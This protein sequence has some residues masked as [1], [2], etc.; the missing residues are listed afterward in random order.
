ME[1][2]SGVPRNIYEHYS[3]R[4]L[5]RPPTCILQLCVGRDPKCITNKNF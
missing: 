5:S 3:L 2:G 4:H 1:E